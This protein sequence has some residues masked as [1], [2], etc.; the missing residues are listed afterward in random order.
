MS[1]TK[2]SRDY[3][4]NNREKY[5][6]LYGMKYIEKGSC[7]GEAEDDYSQE[8]GPN[9]VKVWTFQFGANIVYI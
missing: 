6:V 2:L 9:N 8:G 3:I 5:Y 4:P 7:T 1:Y